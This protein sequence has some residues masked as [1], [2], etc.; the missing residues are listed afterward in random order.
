VLD[1]A[2]VAFASRDVFKVT[3]DELADEVGVTKPVL[4][5]R[6]GSKS[7]V[8]E[9][10]VDAQCRK[11]EE[12]LFAAYDRA[13]QADAMEAGR[14]G[15]GAFLEYA[16]REPHSFRLLFLDSHSHSDAATKRIAATMERIAERV[17]DLIRS[18][19]ALR[20]GEVGAGAAEALGTALVG[21]NVH[22]A[23][24]HVDGRWD[25]E[26]LTE[27]LAGFMR[28]GLLGVDATRDVT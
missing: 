19:L 2:A 1:A 20:T 22:V 25:R 24:R 17:A 26:E 4:Y 28:A 5:R 16:E 9:A 11:L 3:M 21:F 18:A 6:F 14:I 7:E 27:L 8:F 23:L 10:T 13:K 15:F 12:H